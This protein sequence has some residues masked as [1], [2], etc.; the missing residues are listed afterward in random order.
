MTAAA[1]L[2]APGK[3]GALISGA[4][5]QLGTDAGSWNRTRCA[6]DPDRPSC[7]GR[8]SDGQKKARRSM[9]T[10]TGKG[11]VLLQL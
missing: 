10:A 3:L 8:Q 11:Y 9:E 2:I 6:A 1:Q 4:R 5:I 7:S